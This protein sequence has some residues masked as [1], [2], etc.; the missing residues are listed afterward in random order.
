MKTA[1]SLGAVALIL[2]GSANATCGPIMVSPAPTNPNIVVDRPYV[3]VFAPAWEADRVYQKGEIVLH[4]DGV[5]QARWWTQNEEPGPTWA[6]WEKLKRDYDQWSYDDVYY[7][8]DLVLYQGKAYQAQYW[9]QGHIPANGTP[10][11]ETEASKQLRA[12]N[13]IQ[14]SYDC[15]A[16]PQINPD[17]SYYYTRHYVRSISLAT[18]VTDE[19]IFDTVRFSNNF[20]GRVEMITAVIDGQTCHGQ[21]ACNAL[22][23]GEEKQVSYYSLATKSWSKTYGSVMPTPTPQPTYEPTPSYVPRIETGELGERTVEPPTYEP[24]PPPEMI[25]VCNNQDMCREVKIN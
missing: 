7:Q 21:A 2:A 14:E 18:E 13:F 11:L 23:N 6:S 22:L 24:T 4:T 25:L 17:G 9:T 5:Y 19:V 12:A 8:D 1:L 15:G 20:T 16:P 10:W 3:D